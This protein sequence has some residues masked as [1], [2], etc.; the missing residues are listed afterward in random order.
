[1][2]VLLEYLQNV[3]K[4]LG[5]ELLVD[6]VDVSHTTYAK[7][8][9]QQGHSFTAQIGEVLVRGKWCPT[10]CPSGFGMIPPRI[11]FIL[12]TYLIEGVILEYYDYEQMGDYVSNGKQIKFLKYKEKPEK[13][14]DKNL[15][16]MYIPYDVFK[17]GIR[18]VKVYLAMKLQ[19]AGF[20]LNY[21]KAN[22]YKEDTELSMSLYK[23][24]WK[25]KKI[26]I[27]NA[28]QEPSIITTDVVTSV[29]DNNDAQETVNQTVNQTQNTD[30]VVTEESSAAYVDMLAGIQRRWN[31]SLFE[32]VTIPPDHPF[33]LSVDP[34]SSQTQDIPATLSEDVINETQCITDNQT[35]PTHSTEIPALPVLSD[36]VSSSS[37][38][39]TDLLTETP[40]QTIASNDLASTTYSQ[41]ELP[42]ISAEQNQLSTEQNDPP[43][44]S[45]HQ[46]SNTLPTAHELIEALSQL[47]LWVEPLPVSTEQNPVS[48]EQNP[49]S[50]EQNPIPS[51][52][53][54]V[55]S[56]STE[57]LPI[58]PP[59]PLPLLPEPNPLPVEPIQPLPASTVQ[60]GPLDQKP[61]IAKCIHGTVK[62]TKCTYCSNTAM[63]K[64]KLNKSSFGHLYDIDKTIYYDANMDVTMFCKVHGQF[65]ARGKGII[66][67]SIRCPKCSMQQV[68]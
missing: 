55:P 54:S 36:S 19:E 37:T 24:I 15:F 45:T 9:C 38:K 6:T 39:D 57:P 42:V 22:Y 28:P 34:P 58:S 62:T 56:V 3:V 43:L 46:E 66:D 59:K 11:V 17:K 5:A 40:Q 60:P 31:R 44:Q 8:K 50:S 21:D 35:N 26:T 52:Q 65:Y 29:P 32:W 10:C 61:I 2:S 27:R 51:E 13:S 16:I 12:C 1:M 14:T 49:V 53:T 25:P 30:N 18:N 41:S 68:V 67:G 63:F 64:T 48:L 20:T 47:P 7:L 23:A 4:S 33:L